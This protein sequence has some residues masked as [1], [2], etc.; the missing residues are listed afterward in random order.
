MT[1]TASIA[2]AASNRYL[3]CIKACQ[4]CALAC[5]QCFAACL[6]EDDVKMMARCIALDADCAATCE[7]AAGAM[8]RN[9][10]HAQ[11]LCAVCAQVC[12]ACGEECARHEADHCQACA[13]AC[14]QC[15]DACEAMAGAAA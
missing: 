7:L 6:A 3:D 11:A 1:T 13:T 5:H 9:S 4:D 2:N 12:R 8:A 14:H 15:A 10:E